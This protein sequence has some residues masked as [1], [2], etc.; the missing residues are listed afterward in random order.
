MG[1]PA[2]TVPAPGNCHPFETYLL[3]YR[4]TGLESGL[5]RYLALDPKLCYPA[6]QRASWDAAPQAVHEK[7]TAGRCLHLDGGPLPH[8]MAIQH[9]GAHKMIAQDSGHASARTSTWPA[10]A[11]G[12]GTCAVAAVLSKDVVDALVG[13]DGVDEVHRP[14]LAQWAT[15]DRRQG[16]LL[17]GLNWPSESRKGANRC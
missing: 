5:Y 12:A 17:R 6:A 11:I 7:G 10:E 14:T 9:P 3:L 13:V 15:S 4:V 1:F 2:R 8:G 16:V